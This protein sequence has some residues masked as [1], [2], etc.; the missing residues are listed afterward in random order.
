M[1]LTKF[2]N[3]RWLRSAASPEVPDVKGPPGILSVSGGPPVFA[4]PQ[5]KKDCEH[6]RFWECWTPKKLHK[7]GHC[8][9][10]APIATYGDDYLHDIAIASKLLLWWA[11]REWK[12][13]PDKQMADLMID[14]ESTFHCTS[15]PTTS[16]DDWCGEWEVKTDKRLHRRTHRK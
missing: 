11:V 10:R 14:C 7:E 4:E 6:C 15:W 3:V 2:T 1:L 8:H 12:G 16:Q 5:M 9:R 13:D